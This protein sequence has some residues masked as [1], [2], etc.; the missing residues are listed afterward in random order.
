MAAAVLAA[1]AQAQEIHRVTGADV[2]IYNL[3]GRVRVVGGSSND[4]VVR[5]TRG[6]D[7]ASELTVQTGLIDGR[8]T[9]RIIYPGDEIVYPAIGRGS[10][11]SFSVERDGTFG[12]GGGRGD[13]GGRVDIR[14]AGPGLEAW[15]DLVVEVPDGGQAAVY[16]AA[17]ELDAT[18][19]DATLRLD[20]GSGAVT[21]TDISGALTVDTGSGDVNVRGVRG[22]L[23]LDTGSGSV[24]VSDIVGDDV[25]LDSGSGGVDASGIQTPRLSVDTGSGS[26]QLLRVSSPSVT[27]DT[28]SG[29]VEIEL[30]EDVELLEVDSG[31]GSVTVTAPSDLGGTVEIDTG[32]GGI[33]LDFPLEVRSVRRDRVQGR[34]GD[35]DGTITIDTGSGSIR[36]VRGGSL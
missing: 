5:V 4:V 17:G 20:I 19:V 29:S 6:G 36:I 23:H 8:A 13:R 30:L 1:P 31:S 15:A 21:A 2:A 33:D 11:S 12:D 10:R 9:L 34:L 16:V 14:G 28:G 26:V 32:S 3:A 27:V 25:S 24:R 22:T 35:G 7:D 18:G